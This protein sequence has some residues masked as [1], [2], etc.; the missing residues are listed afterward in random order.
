MAGIARQ[1]AREQ[2]LV[3]KGALRELRAERCSAEKAFGE[4]VR[5]VRPRRN[6][7]DAPEI[8]LRDRPR[9]GQ[10]RQQ[11][12]AQQRR[13]AGAARAEDQQER[14]PLVVGAR[15]AQP[16]DRL[17]DREFAAEEHRV[18]RRVEGFETRKRRSMQ[19]PIPSVAL[20]GEAALGQPLAQAIFNLQREI[21]GRGVAL[22][23][24][25]ELAVGGPEPGVEEGLQPRPLRLD[26]G[27]V[28][29]IQRDRGR[30]G[31][32]E[33]E[34]VGQALAALARLDRRQHLIG[35]AARIGLARRQMRK[36]GREFRA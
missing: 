21:V 30:T 31:I 34:N 25:D 5:G 24:R 3:G 10:P 18:A 12:G 1:Q 17:P 32:A 4:R 35:R 14:Q 26:L 15:L 13:L 20:G 36:G 16:L 27:A 19:Q 33:D 29:R 2:R 7:R 6:D 9:Q 28:G 11:S 8:D 23:R 22:E